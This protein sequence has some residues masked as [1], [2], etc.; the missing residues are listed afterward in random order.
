MRWENMPGGWGW[1]EGL[2]P[3]SSSDLSADPGW[4]CI[5]HVASGGHWFLLDRFS[6]C[7]VDKV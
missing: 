7:K 2:R 3:W 4:F 6:I 5:S 1:G